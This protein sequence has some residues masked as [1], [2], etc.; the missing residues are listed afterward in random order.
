MIFSISNFKGIKPNADRITG[1]KGGYREVDEMLKHVK[2]SECRLRRSKE[3]RMNTD[4]VIRIYG[5]AD[6]TNSFSKLAKEG[7]NPLADFFC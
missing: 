3:T 1:T 4:T 5:D 6:N 7:V 2:N